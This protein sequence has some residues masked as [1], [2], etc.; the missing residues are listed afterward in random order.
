MKIEHITP[1]Q[2]LLD[3]FRLGRMVY[4]SGF[5][6]KYAI[7]VWRGG[8]Q[9]GL[10]VN[11]FLRNQGV[12]VHHSTIATESYTGL[13]NAKEVMVKGLDQLVRNI[14]PEDPVLL[15][16]DVFERG[17]T[18]R[19]IIQTFRERAR[20]NFPRDI[21]VATVHRKPGRIRWCD[22]QLMYLRDVEDDTWIDYPHELADLITDD[23][24]DP[25]IRDKGEDFA[26][27]LREDLFPT[28]DVRWDQPYRYLG[29][30]EVLLDSMRLGVNIWAD[31]DFRPDFL[32]ALWPGGIDVGLPVHEVYKYKNRKSGERRKLP[33]HIS[34]NTFPTQQSFRTDIQ[35][36]EYLEA[37]INRTD[38]V[39]VID[40][41]FR[42][43][44]AV[45]DVV[46][47][48]K[49]A[50]RRNM[51][52]ERVR[53]ASLYWDP[54]DRSTW[55]VRPEFTAPHYFL[56]KTNVPVIYPHNVHR[57]VDPRRELAALNP[58]LARVLYG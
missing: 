3:S 19:A 50:L 57:L 8:T 40:S 28:E 12:Q 45:N 27:I 9:V 32:V 5:R 17:E 29:P 15:I 7:S 22:V 55:T 11:S 39:L 25:L 34:V 48:L 38:N 31:E 14:C 46:I 53:V 23:P 51:S 21:R 33:D 18:V 16:D 56:K 44:Q 20:A 54:N 30:R 58:E 1:E 26:A 6:P 13:G 49:E 47:R 2:M 52:N 43:G 4:E 36:L 37:R 41:T 35:G 24:G 42:S 10:G